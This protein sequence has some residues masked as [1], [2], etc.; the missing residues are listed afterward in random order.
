MAEEGEN[1][2]PGRELKY[3]AKIISSLS[4]YPAGDHKD[5]EIRRDRRLFT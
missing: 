1:P 2:R 5:E 3:H 4:S